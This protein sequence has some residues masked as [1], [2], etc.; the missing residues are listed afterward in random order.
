MDGSYG[1]AKVRPRRKRCLDGQMQ[2][3]VA[4]GALVVEDNRPIVSRC[5]AKGTRMDRDHA[6]GRIGM[7]SASDGVV[8][9]CDELRYNKFEKQ[10]VYE[11]LE[12]KDKCRLLKNNSFRL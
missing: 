5:V 6:N 2:R 3:A 10:S 4:I 12:R 11:C 9:R 7:R 1:V 8:I